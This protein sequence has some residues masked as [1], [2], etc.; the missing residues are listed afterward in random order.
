MSDSGQEVS[1]IQAGWPLSWGWYPRKPR[2]Q[3]ISTGLRH[4]LRP[5]E[6]AVG[7]VRLCGRG[8][9]L[10]GGRAGRGPASYAG[11]CDRGCRHF[12]E[13]RPLPRHLGV[14]HGDAQHGA[15]GARA[16]HE[17]GG[18]CRA[19]VLSPAAGPAWASP[20]VPPPAGAR[21]GWSR[22][23]PAPR[24]GAATRS[25]PPPRPAAPSATPVL[26]RTRRRGA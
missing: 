7:R 1:P 19:G 17:L 10:G 2:P 14:G 16:R 26:S 20:A 12:L 4:D 18:R 13:R 5:A 15:G 25:R 3:A 23:T 6:G 22:G 24:A 21:A 9:V 11:S 8:G